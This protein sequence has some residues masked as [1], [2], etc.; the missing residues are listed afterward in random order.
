MRKYA[1]PWVAHKD[2]IFGLDDGWYLV[3]VA[4]R[5]NNPIHK[6]L[7][8]VSGHATRAVIGSFSV[9]DPGTNIAALAHLKIIR[10]IDDEI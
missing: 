3:E 1:A 9:E 7:M 8:E 4:F 6:A 2:S 5:A 10:M